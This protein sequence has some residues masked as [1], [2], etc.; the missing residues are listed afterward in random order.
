MKK[1]K[2]KSPEYHPVHIPATK[3]L[4][5][6]VGNTP[7]VKLRHITSELSKNV[8]IYAK[9]EW[10][11]P[12][13]SIKDRAALFIIRDAEKSGKL[14][15]NQTLLDS[16]SGNMGIAYATFAAAR[17]YNVTL[18]LPDNVSPERKKTLQALGANL[19]FTDSM[20]GS[21]GAIIKARE[22]LSE[23]PEKYYYADQYNNPS[24]WHGHYHTTGP[25]II[26]QT[27]N[28][29][30]HFLCGLGT[31]GTMMGAGS[32]LKEHNNNIKIIAL[33]PAGPFHG[34]E[35]LKHMDS[36]IKPGFYDKNLPDIHM[37]IQTE[38]ALDMTRRLAKEEGLLVGISSGAAAFAA[39]ELGK[40]LSSGVIVTIFCDNGYKYLSDRFW[41]DNTNKT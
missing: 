13:G 32:Y 28:Q 10:T 31:S 16:T 29:I 25:E 11:N 17:G 41:T 20:E 24:S 7:L 26:N 4:E 18:C 37:P 15:S 12:G 5:A 40:T 38:D 27:Q 3:S 6:S 30:T 36:S 33:Q 22:L 1:S 39:I 35:G 19:I 9:T 2:F 14:T 23:N 8:E 34:I 21:D